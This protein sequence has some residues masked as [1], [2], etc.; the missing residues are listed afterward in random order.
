LL[1]LECVPAPLAK[2]ISQQLKIPVIG[3][4]AGQDCDGQVLVLYDILNISAGKKPFFSQ[5][6]LQSTGSIQGAIS[7]FVTAVKNQQ[8]PTDAHCIG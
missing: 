4:G 5:D 8:F 3:I 1:V 6:F 2:H 7:A